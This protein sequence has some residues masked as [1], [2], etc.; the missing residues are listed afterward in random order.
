LPA[1]KNHPIGISFKLDPS[2]NSALFYIDQDDLAV[3]PT[4]NVGSFSALDCDP[5]RIFATRDSDF[6]WIN[7]AGTQVYIEAHH[8]L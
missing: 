7:F 3:A 8:A 4:R 6:R 5:E 2:N 1:V